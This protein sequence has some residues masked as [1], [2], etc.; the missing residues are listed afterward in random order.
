M[1]RHLLSGVTVMSPGKMVWENNFLNV[2]IKGTFY[3]AAVFFRLCFLVF[4]PHSTL[5]NMKNFSRYNLT[6]SFPSFLSFSPSPL[7]SSL[8]LSFLPSLH[9]SS[10]VSSFFSSTFSFPY[11]YYPFSLISFFPLSISAIYLFSSL[12]YL[13]LPLKKLPKIQNL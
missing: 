13:F 2:F 4:L 6:S 3:Y 12:L 7:P 8:L 1:V 10:S 11:S 9:S 5:G